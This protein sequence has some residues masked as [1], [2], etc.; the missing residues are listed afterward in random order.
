[1]FQSFLLFCEGAQS[2]YIC[3][4][5]SFHNFCDNTFFWFQMENNYTVKNLENVKKKK[6]NKEV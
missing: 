4:E 3:L 6:H 1:M 2:D 5:V